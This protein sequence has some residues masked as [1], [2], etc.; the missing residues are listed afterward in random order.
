M[1]GVAFVADE[2]ESTFGVVAVA[3]DGGVECVVVGGYGGVGGAEG[4]FGD[5]VVGHGAEDAGDG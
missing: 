1:D 3:K 2:L 4:D 5:E